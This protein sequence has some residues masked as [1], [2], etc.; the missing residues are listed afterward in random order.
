MNSLKQSTIK[1]VAFKLKGSMLTTMIMQLYTTDLSV[2][3]RQLQKTVQTAPS[4]FKDVPLVLDLQYL[5]DQ[6][7]T[8][9]WQ[10]CLKLLNKQGLKTIGFNTNS[11]EISQQIP[12]HSLPSLTLAQKNPT[13]ITSK[14]TKSDP[15]TKS[16]IPVRIIDQPVRSGQQ[17][18]AEGDLVILSMVSP[19]AEILA[20]GNIHIYGHLRGRALAGVNDNIQAHIFC[21]KLEAELVSIA[22]QYQINEELENNVLG[23]S[24]RIYL[25][26]N[27]LVIRPFAI[28]H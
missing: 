14:S 5:D 18:V 27:N 7:Q 10:A 15:T 3:S 28:Q 23:K 8:I 26:D 22:G 9:D 20:G 1:N 12:K 25:Q 19:G 16:P 6:Q 4:L 17:I 2:L 24:E 11:T 21:H 13:N